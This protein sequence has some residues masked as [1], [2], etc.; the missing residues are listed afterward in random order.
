MGHHSRV[1]GA[2]RVELWRDTELARRFLISPTRSVRDL[3][4][5]YTVCWKP[6]AASRRLNGNPKRR[7]SHETIYRSLFIQARDALKKS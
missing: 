2:Q 5:K 3:P 6:L 4:A 1:S 7:V